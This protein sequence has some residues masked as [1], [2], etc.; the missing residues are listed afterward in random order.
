MTW[1][2]KTQLFITAI[3]L[4][5]AVYD[6]AA[7]FIGGVDATISRVFLHGGSLVPAIPFALG[8]VCGH[9]TWPQP[10]PKLAEGTKPAAVLPD[11]EKK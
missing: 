6:F 10:A 5:V 1:Q 7:M 4:I 11:E 8:Y 9:L 3:V 2:R